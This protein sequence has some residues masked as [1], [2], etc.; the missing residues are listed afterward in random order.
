MI[1]REEA[2]RLVNEHLPSANMRS[3][4][5]AVALVM[6]ALARQ[7]HAD[8]DLWFI[9]GLLHDIDY[10]TTR[11]DHENHGLVAL[12]ILAGSGLPADALEAI[13]VHP[14]RGERTTDIARAL[15]AADP[16][17]GL[18]I[19][20]ALMRPDRKISTIEPASLRKKY[21]TRGFAAG[22]NREQIALCGEIGLDLDTFLE[23]SRQAMAPF[24]GDLIG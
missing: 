6:E 11:D 21:K 14:G 12:Q 1:T 7:M 22:A 4:S 8:P 15:F 3:H 19:A 20:A 5:L 2:S 23:L 24:E 9:V 13:K 18:V 17:T 10:E 16:V